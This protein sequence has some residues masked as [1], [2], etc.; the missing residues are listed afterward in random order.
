MFVSSPLSELI[1]CPVPLLSVL[2]FL[3]AIR[4]FNIRFTCGCSSFSSSRTS[5]SIVGKIGC[6]GHIVK[7]CYE[8][9]SSIRLL[10][11]RIATDITWLHTLVIGCVSLNTDAMRRRGSHMFISAINW[12]SPLLC[13]SS[14]LHLDEVID[15]LV[16]VSIVNTLS[17]G[18][19]SLFLKTILSSATIMCV[20]WRRR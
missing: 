15:E 8:S 6:A 7:S 12:F 5:L 4:R 13:P 20:L 19:C 3:P 9:S 11:D 1:E 18:R 2:S 16:L 10:Q 17:L 14:S